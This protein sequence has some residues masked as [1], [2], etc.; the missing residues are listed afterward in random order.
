MV[1]NRKELTRLWLRSAR[2]IGLRLAAICLGI[3]MGFAGRHSHN[4]AGESDAGT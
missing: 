1:S 2:L 4:Q 3:V